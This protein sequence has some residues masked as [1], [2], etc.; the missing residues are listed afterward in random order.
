MRLILSSVGKE[1]SL[2][3]KLVMLDMGE[4]WGSVRIALATPG[5]W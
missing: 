2:V 4:S 3:I 5:I 1:M